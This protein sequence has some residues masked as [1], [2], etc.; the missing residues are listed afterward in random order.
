[1]PALPVFLFLFQWRFCAGSF[2][3][4]DGIYQEYFF[5]LQGDIDQND[6]DWYFKQRTDYRCKSLLGTDP[7]D[8]NGDCDAGMSRRK[9]TASTNITAGPMIQ[10]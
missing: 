5:Q 10:F 6:Q 2:S 7:P 3:G 9:I 8:R 1:M 4:A